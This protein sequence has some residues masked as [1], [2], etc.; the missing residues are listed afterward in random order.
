MLQ[1]LCIGQP[2]THALQFIEANHEFIQYTGRIDFSNPKKPKIWAPGVYIKAKFKGTA[3]NV[4]INDE[5]HSLNYIEI[6]IDD[7]K[8]SRIQM[9]QKENIIKA[10]EGLSPGEHTITI[11]KNTE[12]N[13][14]YIEFIGLECEDL[15]PLSSKP[16]RRIEFIGNSI[17]CGTGSDL[18]ETACQKGKW[19]DQHNAYMS[20]G[21][22]AAR[23]L[24]AEWHLTAYSGIGLIQSCCNLTITMPQIFDKVN[25]HTQNSIPWD[26]NKYQPH[27]VTICLGQND[28]IQD[29]LQFCGAY[30][31]FIENIRNRY[32]DAH[33][34]CLTSP[35]AD[36]NLTRGLKNYLTGV[37]DYAGKRD[38]KLHKYFFSRSYNG[39][40]DGH[41]D[42]SEHQLLADELAGYLGELMRWK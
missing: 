7:H 10:A 37:V 30:V 42:L 17:T 38:K 36:A 25:L 12:T 39:G 28:G 29:S 20:Y 41:P 19:H 5:G 18:S 16:E 22:T 6:L 4:V 24:N 21:P 32:P 8:P 23:K 26:F 33:I 13:I 27:V 1:F 34:V 15:L 40:C 9:K 3:C 31:N 35:M 11:C 14:G 2:S